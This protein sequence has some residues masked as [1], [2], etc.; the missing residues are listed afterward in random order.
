[1]FQNR[2]S[3]DSI[4]DHTYGHDLIARPPVLMGPDNQTNN[5]NMRRMTIIISLWKP[6]FNELSLCLTH[7]LWVINYDSYDYIIYRWM[8]NL[9]F[10]LFIYIEI[11]VNSVFQ[12]YAKPSINYL[13]PSH[14]ISSP[15]TQINKDFKN[16]TTISVNCDSRVTPLEG[17]KLRPIG[18]NFPQC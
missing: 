9:L 13:T 16:S 1:M 15:R 7:N 12:C 8:K 2:S 3:W 18:D 14:E 5:I 11:Y 10:N 17:L 6:Y 4:W